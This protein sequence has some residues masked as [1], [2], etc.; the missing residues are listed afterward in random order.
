MIITAPGRGIALWAMVTHTERGIARHTRADTPGRVF[1][2]YAH[3][4][5]PGRG[6]HLHLGGVF[7]LPGCGCEDTRDSML[8]WNHCGPYQSERQ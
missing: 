6:I 3:E 2:P 4:N 1:A 8:S 5:A 7:S